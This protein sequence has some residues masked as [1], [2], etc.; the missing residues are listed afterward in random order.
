[1]KDNK[2]NISDWFPV[3]IIAAIAIWFLGFYVMFPTARGDTLAKWSFFAWNAK[4]DFIHGRIIPFAFIAFVFIGWKEM[5]KAHKSPSKL[6]LLFCAFGVLLYFASIRT[7]QPRLALV[8]LPFIILGS[9]HFLY[10]WKVTRV[11]LF[12][13]FF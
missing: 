7:I 1:M 3:I 12:P 10:G 2:Q 5:V 8:G 9:V 13:A 11:M 4:N 6:G